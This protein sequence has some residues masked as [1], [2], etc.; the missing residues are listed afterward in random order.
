MPKLIVAN[1]KMN[2]ATYAAAE[3]LTAAV[4]KIPAGRTE[5]V[6]CPP[7][8]WLTDFSHKESEIKFGAQ[9][10]FW[11]NPTGPFTGQVSAQMLTEAKV[12]YVIIGH[13][14]RRILVGETDAMVNKKMRAAALARLKP[15]LCVGEDRAVRRQG[16]AAAKKFVAGQL[17]KD[18]VGIG[19]AYPLIVA[20]EPIWA[21]GGGKADTP[22]TAA[23][24]AW[25]I[26]KL[27]PRARVLYGG[28]VNSQNARNFLQLKEID[29]AL[30]GGASLKPAE[31][32]K[33]I[34]AANQ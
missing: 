8:V 17:K 11:E 10:I 24:M 31:F 2:P 33:I 25:Y 30:V 29:G 19:R 28:S 18:L 14:E 22:T 34:T 5:V 4:K 9:D 13:S 12:K 7:L 32:E 27:R 3:R 15:I 20:Y 16:L 1:W 21:I 6:I 23:E 26:K